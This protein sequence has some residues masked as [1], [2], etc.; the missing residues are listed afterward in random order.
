[1]PIIVENIINGTII[2]TDE[3]KSYNSLFKKYIY[4]R[5]CV[6]NLIFVDKVTGAHT[7]FVERF[8]NE[9]K[10]YNIKYLKIKAYKQDIVTDPS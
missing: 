9:Y 4:T 5:Q 8:D 10:C 7:Q 2:Y 3:H 1:M 6:T